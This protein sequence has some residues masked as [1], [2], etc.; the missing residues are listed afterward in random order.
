LGIPSNPRRGGSDSGVIYLIFP[1]SGNQRPRS[2]AEIEAEGRRLFERWGGKAQ[3][4]ECFSG[5]PIELLNEDAR[6]MDRD[7]L[8]YKQVSDIVAAH[9]KSAISNEAII[10]QIWK[11]SSFD[12][13]AESST[14]TA[15]GLMGITEPAV[16]TVNN[17]TPPGIHFEH[18]EM[19]DPIRNV[20]CGT[21]YLKF[22]M[23]TY[24]IKEA[25]EHFGTGKGYADNILTCET[26]L[27][28]GPANPQTCLNA[29]HP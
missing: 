17:S 25:L 21:Y 3:I 26:C 28:A 29:I 15:T 14:T 24:P 7:R 22:L 8:T 11:E 18:S 16:D 4:R 10:A 23:K 1:G 20:E 6:L 12:P 19:K 13:K 5:T 2:L 27:K 9:N